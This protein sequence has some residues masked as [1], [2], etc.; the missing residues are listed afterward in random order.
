M[1]S[2]EKAIKKM[3]HRQITEDRTTARVEDDVA[4]GTMLWSWE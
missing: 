4:P 1:S 2:H 3:A